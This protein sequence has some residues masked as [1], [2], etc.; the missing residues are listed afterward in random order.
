MLP[1]PMFVN[2]VILTPVI[3]VS[4]DPDNP[5]IVYELG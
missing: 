4:V 1:V 3:E 2:V 5:D